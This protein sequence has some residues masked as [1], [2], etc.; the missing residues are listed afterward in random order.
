MSQYKETLNLPQTDFPMKA[1]LAQRE[2]AILQQWQETKLYET[3]SQNRKDYPLFT[4]MDGP[5]YANGH[6]HVGH[7]VNI[8]LKD[9]IIKSK[10][11][12]G[13]NVPFVPGWDCHGLPIELNVEKK[14]GKPGEKISLL[15]F[16]T[17]CRTYATQYVD[18]Q[19]EEFKRLGVIGDWDHPYLTMNPIYEANIIR[20]LAQIVARGYIQKGYKPVHWCLN[21]ASALAEAEVEYKLKTSLAIDVRFR[22]K[23][24]AEF[25]HRFKLTLTQDPISIPIWTTT[26]WTLPANQAVAVNAE[27]TYVLIKCPEEYL[28]IVADL[29][30]EALARYG[31]KDY[32]IS[33]EFKGKALE[34]LQLQHPFYDRVVPLVLGDHV[35]IEAG[36]GAVHTAP[37]HGQDDYVIGLHYQLPMMNPVGDDGCFISNTPLFAGMHV[38]KVQDAIVKQLSAHQ[39][40]IVETKIEHSYPHCWRHKTPLIFRATPQWFIN[41]EQKD[42][43]QH[44]LDAIKRVK[45]IPERGEARIRAMV[46]NHPDW[47]VSRQRT[48]GVPLCFFIHKETGDLHPNTTEL[49]EVIATRV[50]KDGIEAWHNLEI[51]ELL[52]ADAAHYK[53]STDVLDVWFDSGVTH[54]C[55][56]KLHPEVQF[57]A[58]IVLEGSDQHRGWF[59]S[60]LLTS[61]ALYAKEPYKTVLTHG[62]VVDGQGHKMSKSLGNVISLEESVKTLGA[63]ILRLWAASIDYRSEITASKELLLPVSETYRRIRNTMRFLLANMHGFDPSQHL[64]PA[65]K[66]L[67]LDRYIVHLAFELQQEIRQAYN[68]YHFHI[69]VQKLHQFCINELGG[70]YL[71]IIKDRQYTMPKDSIGRRSA[72]TALYHLVQAMLRWMAPILSFTAEEIWQY[73]PGQREASILMCTWYEALEALPESEMMNKNYWQKI[74][75]VRDAVN[76]EIE[77]QRNAEKIGS[78]LEAEVSVYADASLYQQLSHLKEELRFILITSS[79][80][81]LPLTDVP[82]DAATTDIAGLKLK[83]EAST[84]QKCD[85]CW[86]RVADVNHTPNFPML[87]SRCVVNISGVGETR[88]YA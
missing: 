58:D 80:K 36:T 2:P 41:M 35:T 39:T 64:L 15:E 27:L 51:E 12:E 8:I 18:I 70:F 19:R 37:A 46:E 67:L 26:P 57:P 72:Q 49:M 23:D 40:L 7:A 86:H 11:L 74:R 59:Q 60:Q 17:A 85:R 88:F 50:E 84:H 43:K 34:G 54:S 83:I 14:Y 66:M 44:A 42:L 56:P 47:C 55:V 76:K 16:L 78:A 32:Q 75:I 77:Q 68:H 1:N 69:I 73:V 87:C 10:I 13:F 63:D 45:W 31:I 5:P 29:L 52:G 48:W 82:N 24:A 81:V 25:A 61:V 79:A 21:C 71:D 22:L 3:L 20:C 62:F 53:K 30:S 65:N 38:N 9:I 33:A 28:I 6:L 4:F